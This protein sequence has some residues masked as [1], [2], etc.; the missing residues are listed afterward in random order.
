VCL[1]VPAS[2]L[3]KL[4]QFKRRVRFHGFHHWQ[5]RRQD[6]IWLS[7]DDTDTTATVQNIL[8]QFSVHQVCDSLLCWCCNTS[9]ASG[10]VDDVIFPCNNALY[11]G[12]TLPQHRCSVVHGLTPL[13]RDIGCVQFYTTVHAKTRRVLRARGDRGGL[14]D[15]PFTVSVLHYHL[16]DVIR[17]IKFH[18]LTYLSR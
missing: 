11:N 7:P 16:M 6:V 18:S 8:T 13:L 5:A 14:C 15:A 10:F 2:K 4:V 9:R 12:V 3:S 17:A 1:L